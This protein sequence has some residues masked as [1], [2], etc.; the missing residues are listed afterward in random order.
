MSVYCDWLLILLVRLVRDYHVFPL[1]EIY[2]L[3]ETNGADYLLV[4]ET[5]GADYLLVS[6]TDGA[7]YLLVSE[8]NGADLSIWYAL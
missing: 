6:E 2:R 3:S 1:I 8:T 5:N 4:S 7:D